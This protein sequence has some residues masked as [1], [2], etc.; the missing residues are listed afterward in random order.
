MTDKDAP[1][2]V[3]PDDT[4]SSAQTITERSGTEKA[5][6]NGLEM[7]APRGNPAGLTISTEHAENLG[8]PSTKR[9]PTSVF[10]TIRRHRIDES[11]G[12]N[13]WASS[14]VSRNDQRAERVDLF[15]RHLL[16]F[17]RKTRNIKPAAVVI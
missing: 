6:D 14:I 12:S 15:E 17:T 2:I 3:D 1:N 8:L 13:P 7:I 16:N 10:P 9:S 11:D 4:E 5:S